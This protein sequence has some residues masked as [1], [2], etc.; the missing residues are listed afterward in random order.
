MVRF[1]ERALFLVMISHVCMQRKRSPTSSALH[2]VTNTIILVTRVSIYELGRW[3]VGLKHPVHSI[4]KTAKLRQSMI[5]EHDASPR[6]HL[7]KTQF[8]T[9]PSTPNRGHSFLICEP[10]QK[11]LCPVIPGRNLET[12]SD[13]SFG[14]FVHPKLVTNYDQMHVI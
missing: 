10:L 11:Y 14:T 1:L 12:Y 4:Q 8:L 2:K 5:Q 7:V 6:T 9:L 3:G 13:F